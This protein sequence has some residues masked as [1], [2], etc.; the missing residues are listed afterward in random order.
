MLLCLTEKCIVCRLVC[1]W[2]VHAYLKH[3]WKNP[4][5]ALAKEN[6]AKHLSPDVQWIVR[7]RQPW[8]QLISLY[9]NGFIN[10]LTFYQPNVHESFKS[11]TKIWNSNNSEFWTKALMLFEP[12]RRLPMDASLFTSA[13]SNETESWGIKEKQWLLAGWRWM[14]SP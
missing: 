12:P 14:L 5:C 2:K 10:L 3:Y 13:D 4:N 7:K 8:Q 9:F 11:T 1:V 6:R